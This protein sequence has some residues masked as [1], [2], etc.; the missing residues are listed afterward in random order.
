MSK[1]NAE[2]PRKEFVEQFDTLAQNFLE[3][4]HNSGSDRTA[5]DLIDVLALCISTM[6][7][8]IASQSDNPVEVMHAVMEDLFTSAM[9][10]VAQQLISDLSDNANATDQTIPVQNA[11]STNTLQ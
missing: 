2:N 6:T 9:S 1:E 11:P 8:R 4:M 7:Y 10:G 5:N 3:K